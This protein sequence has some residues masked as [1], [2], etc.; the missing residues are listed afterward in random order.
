VSTEPAD[1]IAEAACTFG[2]SDDVTVVTAE[3][4]GSGFAAAAV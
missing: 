4:M 1:R 2:Q 3:F